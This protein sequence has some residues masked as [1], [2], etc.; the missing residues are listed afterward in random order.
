MYVE[1]RVSIQ[2]INFLDGFNPKR[3][4]LFGQLDTR[5][6]VESAHYGKRSL[7][8]LNFYFR[9]TNSVSYKLTYSAKIGYPVEVAEVKIV[10]SEGR[11]SSQGPG[12]KK[13]DKKF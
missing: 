11:R 4:R 2:K 6:R 13:F 3:P 10:A 1:T 5:G 7:K 8:P 12:E 9:L